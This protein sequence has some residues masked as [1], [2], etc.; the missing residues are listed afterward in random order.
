MCLAIASPA[1]G[2]DTRSLEIFEKVVRPTL[3]EHCVRC[4]GDKK[5]QGGLR[6]DSRQSLLAGGDSGPAIVPGKPD[7]SLLIQAIRYDGGWEMPPKG[8]L[9]SRTIKA[10]EQW[11]ESGAADPRTNNQKDPDSHLSPTVE[12]GRSF[13]SFQ[14]IEN[15]PVPQTPNA[16]ARSDIDRFVH[17][18]LDQQGLEPEIDADPQTLLRRVHY[19]L[20]GLPPRPEDVRAFAKNPT[21]EAFEKVVDRLLNSP[22]FGQRW[23]RHWLD[24][25]RYAESSGGGRTLLFPNAWRYRD[26]VIDCFNADVPY[27]QFL[28]EQIAGDLIP[29][30]D[31][32]DR[33]RKLT[34]TAYLL[35]GPTNYELQDKDVLEMDVVDEQ[36]DTIGKGLLGMTI[37][38]ARCHDHKFD[39]IPAHDYYALAGILKSTKAM[40]HSN[41]STWNKAELPV[42]P[43]LQAK[44]DKHAARIAQLKTD[45]AQATND[46]KK[47]GGLA[48]NT[49]KKQAIDPD[50]I[51]GIVVD[52]AEAQLVGDWTTSTSINGFVGQN[53]IH[54][55]TDGKGAKQVIFNASLPSPGNYEVR[56]S[57]TASGNRATDVPVHV[58]HQSGTT[59]VRINQRQRP[60][61]DGSFVSLG[62]FTFK[63]SSAR[64]VIDNTA[65]DDGVV[66][67]DSVVFRNDE[68][69]PQDPNLGSKLDAEKLAEIERLKKTVDTLEK[70]LKKLEA[71]APKRPLAMATTDDE[72]AGDIPLAIRGVVHNQGPITPRGVLQVTPTGSFGKIPDG[73]SGRAELAA[74]LTA[75]DNPLTPRVMA[76][77]VWYWLMGRG[78]V[79]TVDNF[80]SMGEAPTHPE[81]LDHLATTL[82]NDGWSTKS[83]IRRIVLS[84]TYQLSSTATDKLRESDPQNQWYGRFNRK[85]L[86][87]EDIRDTMLFVSNELETGLGGSN[88]KPGTK[89]EYGYKFESKRRSVYVPVFRNTLPEVF[90]AFDFADPNIQN[91]KRNSSTIAS[92][93]LWMM[94]HP[95]VLERAKTAAINLND[96]QLPDGEAID[97]AFLQVLGRMP[98]SSEKSIAT[99]FVSSDKNTKARWAMLYQTLFQSL[100]FRYLN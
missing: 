51:P 8:A 18:K 71:N 46:W 95:F 74:W 20:T 69:V 14:P 97:R 58:H 35:L 61:I 12:Q 45:L 2:D 53:Y 16:W 34:A 31:W 63:E 66:I 76:N 83:L 94:N 40:I 60:P 24:V 57:Y 26:Y 86:R 88:I 77:R 37:G 10:L 13:W 25:V 48:S 78:I 90:E 64:V 67:A 19:D 80:G 79:P 98:S 28:Q 92:Q 96:S 89:S 27:D 33:R 30:D 9:P 50:S 56:V 91:G 82:R 52:D 43:Q 3:L 41:V 68:I 75:D 65:T 59:T 62:T 42:E 100:D 39:P 1:I 4:H 55:A 72:D 7:E 23:G 70:S 84:R 38:C 47:A 93:A 11:V 73:Q 17:A 15:P 22:Q 87:A 44:I 54:D 81:L 29:A 36:L 85:R 6:V 5:Q 49:K 32:Q 21:P 99:E